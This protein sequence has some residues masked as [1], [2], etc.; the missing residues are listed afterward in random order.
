MKN[1][2]IAVSGPPGAGST[3]IS[4]ELARRL[5][6]KFFSPGFVQKGLAKDGSNQSQACVEAWESEKGK[7]RE[8]HHDLDR[9]QMELAERGGI[10]ICGKLSIHFLPDADLKVWLDVPLEVRAE[11]SANRDGIP[12]ERAREAVAS[13]EL[14]ERKE[15]KRIYG[16][17]YFDQ[18]NQADLVLDTSEFS[19]EESVENIM[20]FMKEK[21]IV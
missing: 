8:F 16:F 14:V 20:R 13:R 4:Q 10:I 7:S 19:I 21:G 9:R 6:L 5:G 17:D 2:V 15:W 3:T 11:R 12:L 1:L 18:K